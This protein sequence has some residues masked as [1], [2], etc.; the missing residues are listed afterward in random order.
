MGAEIIAQALQEVGGAARGAQPV[1][2]G[3]R[4]GE[5]RHGDA[6]L[7]REPDDAPP[8]RLRLDDRVVEI[9]LEQQVWYERARLVGGADALQEPGADDAAAAPQARNLAQPQDPR[10]LAGGSR[11]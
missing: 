3:E 4:G 2:I 9:A 1:V 5:G 10:Y 6:A 11:P 7:D 8:C